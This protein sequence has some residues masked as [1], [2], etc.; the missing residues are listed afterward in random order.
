MDWEARALV[1]KK[2][3]KNCLIRDKKNAIHYDKT[4]RANFLG[5]FLFQAAKRQLNN[6]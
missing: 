1:S 2:N 6:S 5:K 4:Q 3:K